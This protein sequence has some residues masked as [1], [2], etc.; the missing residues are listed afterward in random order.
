MKSETENQMLGKFSHTIETIPIDSLVAGNNP[1]RIDAKG[2]SIKDLAENIKATGGVLQ[3]IIVRALDL[4]DGIPQYELLAG[5]RRVAASKLAGFTEIKA[6]IY[7]VNNEEARLITVTENLHRENLTPLEEADGLKSLIDLGKNYETIAAEL[8]RLVTWVIRRAKLI[9]LIPEWRQAIVGV[10][11]ECIETVPWQKKQWPDKFKLWGVGHFEIIARHDPETQLEILKH[12][13]E[14][15]KTETTTV[16]ELQNF[17]NGQLQVLKK[18]L[19]KLDDDSLIP[20][21]GACNACPKRTSRAPGLFDDDMT[22]DKIAAN[23]KCIDAKCWGEKLKVFAERKISANRE[24]YP[25]AILIRDN[26]Q[27]DVAAIGRNDY[28][29][30]KKNTPGAKPAILVDGNGTGQVRWVKL[31]KEASKHSSARSK[32]P[33]TG[34]PQAASKKE[35]YEKL[36]RRRNAHVIEAIQVILKS[37]L[38]PIAKDARN[39][40]VMANNAEKIAALA[41]AFGI[42]PIIE[43]DTKH[44]YINN[45]PWK[46][47]EAVLADKAR[48][49]YHVWDGMRLIFRERLNFSDGHQA[50]R[51]IPEAKKIL[52]LLE[53]EFEPFMKAAE[54]EIPVPKSWAKLDGEEKPKAEKKAAKPEGENS[55]TA[56]PKKIKRG[57]LLKK[58]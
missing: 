18:A 54:A 49:I 52:A 27:T 36:Q 11:P 21:A 31:N 35:R 53:L 48:F 9:D 37:D 41:A 33:K 39:F 26:Y 34:K 4:K 22:P 10:I 17:L 30:V 47:Y 20:A 56:K 51:K 50:T 58:K 32:D 3:P 40:P 44:G 29:E 1:R 38:F 28:E 43:W 15:Y 7:A 57:S 23:D 13:Y 24:K 16:E 25:D 5:G 12:F 6:A 19:W 45:D 14:V 42:K 2:A 8:G 55:G 46:K